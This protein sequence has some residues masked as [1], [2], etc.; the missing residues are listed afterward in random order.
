MPV[1]DGITATQIIRKKQESGDI[2]RHVPILGISANARPEQGMLTWIY[3][4]FLKNSI[5]NII[6]IV[7]F[8]TIVAEM[9]AAGMVSLLN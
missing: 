9:R 3:I 2:I 5:L 1:M 7:N 6:L 8:H 4:P